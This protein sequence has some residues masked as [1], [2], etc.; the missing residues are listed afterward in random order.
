MDISTRSITYQRVDEAITGAFFALLEHNDFHG[1]TVSQIIEKAGVNRAT[2]YRHY[3]DKFDILNHIKEVAI[4]FGYEMLAPLVQADTQ[5]FDIL[6]NSSYLSE[7][8]PESYKKTFLLLL[9]VRTESFDMEKIVKDG[10]SSRYNPE[11]TSVDAE[12]KRELYADI[13]YRM[14]IYSI[15]HNKELPNGKELINELVEYINSSI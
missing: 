7:S 3:E 2:F 14:L 12:L 9:K 10:F 11:D 6:F 1:I 13:C 15:T 5:P 8:V 4:N